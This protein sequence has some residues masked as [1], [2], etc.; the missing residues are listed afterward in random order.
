MLAKS[1]RGGVDRL[2][3]SA[4]ACTVLGH[5]L[6]VGA[7]TDQIPRAPIRR[8]G[9]KLERTLVGRTLPRRGGGIPP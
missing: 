5:E 3:P 6:P 4:T 2:E 9:E 1:I 7:G 8:L